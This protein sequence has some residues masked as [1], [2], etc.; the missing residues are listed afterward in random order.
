MAAFVPAS[1]EFATQ[2]ALTVLRALHADN[3][4]WNRGDPE[5]DPRREEILPTK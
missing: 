1:L 5:I 2:D 4:L 3:W